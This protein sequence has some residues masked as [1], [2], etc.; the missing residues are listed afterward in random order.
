MEHLHSRHVVHF[1]LKCDNLMADLRNTLQP[2]VKISD[3]GLSKHKAATFMSGNM[4]GTLPWMAPEMF[5]A[6]SA[7]KSGGGPQVC[8]FRS[9]L[10]AASNS[11][12]NSQQN[13]WA[14]P[15]DARCA[16]TSCVCLI[17]T[18]GS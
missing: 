7:T 6:I 9:V 4:R 15:S 5:P 3:M 13:A 17:P 12:A 16:F 18:S 2:L 8:L 10:C 11:H 14:L 1:D